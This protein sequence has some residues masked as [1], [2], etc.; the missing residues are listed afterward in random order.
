MNTPDAARANRT[1][2]NSL[3]IQREQRSCGGFSTFLDYGASGFH[4]RRS[5]WHRE[6]T[7]FTRA[8]GKG[9]EWENKQVPEAASK[10]SQMRF[11]LAKLSDEDIRL[12]RPLLEAASVAAR[13][14]LDLGSHELREEAPESMGADRLWSSTLVTKTGRCRPGRT[15]H[16]FSSPPGRQGAQKA[17]TNS[18]ASDLIAT[19]SFEKESDEAVAA[20]PW[21]TSSPARSA[22]CSP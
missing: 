9:R 20:G 2:R 7:V 22:N 18:S 8:L 17:R 14:A 11:A 10:E 12:R 5:Q 3:C 21:T 4:Y 16:G 1:S 13:L 19:R 15:R 6:C